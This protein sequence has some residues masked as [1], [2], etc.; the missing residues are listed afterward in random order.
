MAFLKQ[1][2]Y[3]A[4]NEAMKLLSYKLRKQQADA[5]INK[6][7]CPQTKKI[8]HRSDQ[9]QQSFENYYRELYSQP[10]LDNE[11]EMNSCS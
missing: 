3:E 9:I 1:G 10:K 11:D 2:Y 6:I 4:G 5:T 8:E 7:R